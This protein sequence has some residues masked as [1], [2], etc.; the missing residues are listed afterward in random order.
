[1]IAAAG[2]LWFLFPFC[3]LSFG[4]L[5]IRLRRLRRE[6]WGEARLIY[7]DLPAAVTDLG[8]NELTY[9]GAEAQ[10]R[11]TAAEDAGN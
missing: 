7:E 4:G 3:L 6:G 11:R 1:M 10:L 5:W 9:A 2:E 8:I